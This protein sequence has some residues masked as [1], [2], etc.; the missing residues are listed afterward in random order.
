MTDVKELYQKKAQLQ[1][2]KK[3]LNAERELFLS[4]YTQLQQEVAASG[5][6]IPND[7]D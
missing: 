6:E 2:E 3:D 5:T 1:D 4:M 7:D